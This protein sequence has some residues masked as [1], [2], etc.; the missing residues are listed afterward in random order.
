[1]IEGN[2]DLRI[3]RTRKFI[4][5]SFIHLLEKKDFNSITI[6][7]ITLGAMI[8][9]ATFYHHFVDK[10]D[11]LEKVI[12]EELMANVLLELSNDQ[13]FSEE[14]LKRVFLSITKF[15]M[16]LSDRCQRSYY[17]MKMNIESI[18]KKELE[19]IFFQSLL[20]KYEVERSENLRIIATMLSW[21]IYAAVMDWKDRSSK[22]PEDYVEFA[23]LSIRQL[24]KNEDIEKLGF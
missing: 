21:M 22:S 20:K 4:I 17:D 3:I 2:T 13:E 12:K 11:L 16:S 6:R 8:N 15:H 9:R 14:L 23:I 1:M 10:Y 5:N 19:H 24:L 18:I 7:D